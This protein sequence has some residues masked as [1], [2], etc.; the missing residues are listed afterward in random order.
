MGSKP[1]LTRKQVDAFFFSVD[2]FAEWT[3]KHAKQRSTAAEK[4]EYQLIRDG[5]E[6]IVLEY[7]S[8]VPKIDKLEVSVDKLATLLM[9]L[10]KEDGEK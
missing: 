2:Y 1:T 4:V 7:L 9:P 6:S 3:E 10:V 8:M 5:V